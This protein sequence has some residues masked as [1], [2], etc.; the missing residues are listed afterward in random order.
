MKV[1]YT[2]LIFAL[3][4]L[5]M[6]GQQGIEYDA[7]EY[8][9]TEYE[10][11]CIEKEKPSLTIYPNPTTDYFEV[12]NAQTTEG[13]IFD[14]IG[15]RIRRVSLVGVIDVSDL[16]KGVYLVRAGAEAQRVIVQ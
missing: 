11:V 6:W 3:L 8:D 10:T 1:L 9:C 16:P 4:P 13:V 7:S 12:K 15:R 5:S 2:I 14:A